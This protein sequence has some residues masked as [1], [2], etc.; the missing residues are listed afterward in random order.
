MSNSKVIVGLD[1]GTTKV[2][3]MVGE[4][5]NEKLTI[6]AAG[7]SKSEGL[8]RGN[9][10]NIETTTSAI[11]SAIKQAENIYGYEIHDVVV[12]I[13]GDHIESIISKGMV[14]ISGGQKTVRREDVTRVID[15]AKRIPGLSDKEILHVVPLDYGIDGDKGIQQPVGMS[16]LQLSVQILIIAVDKLKLRN[17]RNS[18]LNADLNPTDFVL[19][20]FA[21][22][23]S[24]LSN[25]EKEMGV[26]LIDIG[27]G[28][29]DIA[30]YKNGTLV[31]SKVISM[32]GLKVTDDLVYALNTHKNIA[33]DIKVKY[34]SVD[35]QMSANQ[36]VEI[37][38]ISGRESVYVEK[39]MLSRYI[40]PRMEEIFELV[41]D[42]LRK[43][44]VHQ[45]MNAG[46]VL[47]GGASMLHGLSE[48]AHKKIGLQA[49]IGYP[50]VNSGLIDTASEPK[51][52]T[53]IGLIKYKNSEYNLK[54][55][56][57]KSKNQPSSGSFFDNFL[58]KIRTWLEDAL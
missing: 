53:V 38:G 55:F 15:N 27:G 36:K 18:I 41:F 20:P 7:E 2:V 54:K 28:T 25:S 6:M 29:T 43:I 47:T 58:T 42:H 57:G 13:S 4:I 37:P 11:S 23:Y 16:G 26:C 5:E 32:G 44:D 51:Y 17:L 9:V 35:S 24:T 8:R 19:Q 46:V 34:G 48:I 22:A 39:Q 21:S 30:V 49:R 45:E 1:I 40:K 50:E 56:R 52:A 14:P 33:E 31:D 10:I 3:C 12:G